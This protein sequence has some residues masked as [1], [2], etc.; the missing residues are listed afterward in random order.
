MSFTVYFDWNV[1]NKLEKLNEL[2]IPENEVYSRIKE[3]I[4][5]KKSLS[6]IPM[7]T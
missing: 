1:F 6:L 4:Y 2:S 5:Q 3:V 7:D